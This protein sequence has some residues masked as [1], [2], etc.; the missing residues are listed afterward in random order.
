MPTRPRTTITT[1][2]TTITTTK[3]TIAVSVVSVVPAQSMTTA[4]M[5]QTQYMPL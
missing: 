3:S 1:T 4:I 5:L 2:K